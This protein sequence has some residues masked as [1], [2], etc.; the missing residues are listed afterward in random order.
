MEDSSHLIEPLFERV[1]DYG[2]TSIELLKLKA[3]DK[4]SDVVSTLIPNYF[5]LILVAFF[6]LFMSLAAAFW[7]GDLLGRDY[8][9]FLILGGF[10]AVTALC[11]RFLLNKRLKKYF[12][13]YIVNQAL[14]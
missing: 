8:Y 7:L 1:S 5:V 13:E 9:G 3:I 4:T 6:V 10:Y 2:K 14:K 12:Y 11:F